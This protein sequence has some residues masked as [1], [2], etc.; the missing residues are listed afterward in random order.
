MLSILYI[1][2]LLFVF[3]GYGIGKEGGGSE[4]AEGMREWI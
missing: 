2:R 4:G 3:D 1:Y